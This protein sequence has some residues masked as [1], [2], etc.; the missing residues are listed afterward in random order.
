MHQPTNSQ[1]L[2]WKGMS[3]YFLR[4]LYRHETTDR[5]TDKCTDGQTVR[6]LHGKESPDTSLASCIDMRRQTDRQTD[7]QTNANTA[8]TVRFLPGRGRP[9]TSLAS[10]IDMRLVL[11]P[12]YHSLSRTPVTK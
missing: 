5:Q 12:N 9:D 6:F 4:I 11:F 1:I 3:R 10:C 7:R 2:T 8:K